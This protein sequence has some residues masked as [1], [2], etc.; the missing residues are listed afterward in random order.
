V[1]GHLPRRRQRPLSRQS[2]GFTLSD[3]RNRHALY[4]TDEDLQ[5]A[6]AAFPWV[7]TW[8]DHEVE[9]NYA[10][11]ISEDLVDPERFLARREAAYR[12]YYE[13]MPLRRTSVPQGPDMRMYRGLAYGDLVEFNVL[14]TSQYRDD[15]ANGDGN[16][17][18]DLNS[19]DPGR[20]L[21]GVEQE[22]WLMDGLADSGAR[23]N[24]LAQQTFFAQR[25]SWGGYGQSFN[26][27]AW[28][29]YTGSRDRIVEFIAKRGVENLVVLGGNVHANWANDILTDFNDPGSPSVGT[30]FVGTSIS[31]GGNGYDVGPEFAR[32]QAENPHIKFHNNQRGYVRCRVTPEAWQSD[33]R[34]LPYVTEPG[35]PVATRESFVVE[36]GNSRI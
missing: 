32:V 24:V 36:A 6:H 17:P 16:K 29:G 4:R 8:D 35:A 18:P 30:E 25:D 15:Q 22:R 33:F 20:T 23:W 31:S 26:M 27:D 9:N 14:D 13:H 19:T 5:A 3:Y 10:G 12:A 11:A 1:S 21:M 2:R 28:D 34:I 7:V